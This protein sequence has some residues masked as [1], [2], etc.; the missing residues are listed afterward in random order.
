MSEKKVFYVTTPIYYASARPHLGSLYSTVIADVI[1]RWHQLLGRKI[2]SLTGTDEHGDKIADAAKKAGKT[3][4]QF[5]ETFIGGYKKVWYDY[6]IHYTKF[7]RT[8]DAHHVKGVHSWLRL[9]LER[10]YVYK[11][12]Y[13]GFYCKPCETFIAE[14]ELDEQVMVC[15][16]C[17]RPVDRVE[18]ETYFFKL[19]AFQKPLLDFYKNNPHFILPKERAHE[20]I[21]FVESGLRDLS[22]SRTTVSWG[23]P[24]P[25]DEKHVVY[26]WVD[27]LLNYI[28][29]LGYG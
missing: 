24:F 3:P 2:Y 26:V 8:T 17:K 9:M 27:A 6:H 10:G 7:M 1:A 12:Q 13:A 22:I 16:S 19:S 20:V 4:L 29:A 23:I 21:Q 15:P 25:D 28:T 11:G 14:R 5:I 18:E